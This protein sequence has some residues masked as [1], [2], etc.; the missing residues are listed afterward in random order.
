[1]NSDF[2]A[3]LLNDIDISQLIDQVAKEQI[4]TGAG[5][6]NAFT[7]ALITAIDK[8]EPELKKT[9]CKCFRPYLRL[10]TNEELQY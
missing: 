2:V 9:T 8:S 5:F 1:M 6:S 4:G 10:F 7:N 3:E